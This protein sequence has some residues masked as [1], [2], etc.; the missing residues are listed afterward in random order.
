M[1]TF[2]KIIP[3]P[4]RVLPGTRFNAGAYPRF[5]KA[6]GNRGDA[7]VAVIGQAK[8]HPALINPLGAPSCH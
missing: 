4:I 8:Q 6:F 1:R 5:A 2:S 7:P 3:F